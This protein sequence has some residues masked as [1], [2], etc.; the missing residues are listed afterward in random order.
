MKYFMVPRVDVVRQFLLVE[1]KLENTELEEFHGCG[2]HAAACISDRL[3][4]TAPRVPALLR[5]S[6]RTPIENILHTFIS[7]RM[8]IIIL[9]EI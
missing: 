8:S 5:S 9:L 2:R 4:R 6:L 1:V 3:G 7:C